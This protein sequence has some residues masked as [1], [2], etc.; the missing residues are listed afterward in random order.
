MQFHSSPLAAPMF[1]N[2]IQ[3]SFL[4]QPHLHTVA[5]LFKLSSAGLSKH[6]FV[7]GV[8]GYR[9]PTTPCEELDVDRLGRRIMRD[10]HK[11]KQPLGYLRGDT[12]KF[13]ER[14]TLR[15]S[16]FLRVYSSNSHHVRSILTR[17]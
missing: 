13:V 5:F 10:A 15:S 2:S 17:S 4:G 7:R 16:F 3:Y 11:L 12:Q 8:A 9:E 6:R 1:Y 14:R